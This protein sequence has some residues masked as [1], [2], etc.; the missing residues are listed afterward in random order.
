MRRRLHG[1]SRFAVEGETVRLV[2]GLDDG[3]DD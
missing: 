2:A 3:E 1:S